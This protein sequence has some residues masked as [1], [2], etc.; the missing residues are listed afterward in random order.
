MLN[1]YVRMAGVLFT[2]RDAER[3]EVGEAVILRLSGG[4]GTYA[5]RLNEDCSQFHSI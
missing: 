5:P 3:D 1:L 4:T 2:E